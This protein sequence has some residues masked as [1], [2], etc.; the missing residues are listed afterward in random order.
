M[1]TML[2]LMAMAGAADG[3]PPVSVRAWERDLPARPADLSEAGA[4]A[5][6][7][8]DVELEAWRR[9]R[10]TAYGAL[11]VGTAGVVVA[12]LGC[13]PCG[14]VGGLTAIG[15]FG[16]GVWMGGKAAKTRRNVRAEQLE[17][18][19]AHGVPVLSRV[20]LR[21]LGAPSMDLG[22]QEN[23]AWAQWGAVGATGRAGMVVGGTA[24]GLGAAIGT[25]AVARDVVW[26]VENG[27]FHSGE[28]SGTAGMYVASGVLLGGG[29]V[30]AGTGLVVNQV[31]MS[32]RKR[33]ARRHWDALGERQPVRFGLRGVRVAPM[34]RPGGGGVAVSGRF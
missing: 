21:R 6:D 9:Q 25:V 13:E 1:F 3:A 15:G 12:A 24:L 19:A 30:V 11:G 7:E 18:A 17:I 29:A 4:R 2:T 27:L 10:A 23:R 32:Q 28:G 8:T 20:E 33:L 5:W 14:G 16:T 22:V 34:V 26:V 31:G